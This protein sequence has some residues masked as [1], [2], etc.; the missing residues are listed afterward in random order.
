[1]TEEALDDVELELLVHFVVSV[2]VK[3]DTEQVLELE[4]DGGDGEILFESGMI[5]GVVLM[6]CCEI[7]SLSW[8]SC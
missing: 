3:E 2:Q 5:L 1:M 7:T 4:G 8:T 6:G